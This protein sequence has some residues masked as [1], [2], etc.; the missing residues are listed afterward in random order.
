MNVPLIYSAS[1]TRSPGVLEDEG[2]GV[3]QRADTE[4]EPE[5]AAVGWMGSS[6]G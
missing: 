6:R 1:I 5:G 3:E 4:P 2:G